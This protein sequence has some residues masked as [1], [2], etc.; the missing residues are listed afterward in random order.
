MSSNIYYGAI[1]LILAILYIEKYTDFG[2]LKERIVD[3]FKKLTVSWAVVVDSDTESEFEVDEDEL[4]L[5]QLEEV[6]DIVAIFVFSN[7]ALFSKLSVKD[8]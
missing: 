8:E 5:L 6:R 4:R 1:A 7:S 3:Y 2:L